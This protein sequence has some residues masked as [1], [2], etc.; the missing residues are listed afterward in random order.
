MRIILL[1]S[2]ACTALV[3]AG[4]TTAAMAND[5]Q[6]A[7]QG[8]HHE[9]RQ[10]ENVQVIVRTMGGEQQSI[11]IRDVELEFAQGEVIIN[12]DS[13]RTTS[14][15]RIII[16]GDNID[17]LNLQG[18][19]GAY[20]LRFNQHAD[21]ER[22]T[23]FEAGMARIEAMHP[24]VIH[25]EEMERAMAQVEREMTDLD[26]R[27]IVIVNGEERELTNE[28]RA[29][30]RREL[31][32]AREEIRTSIRDVETGMRA[33]EQE[34]R[35]ALREVRVELDRAER[36][37]ADADG[38][39]RRVRIIVRRDQERAEPLIRELRGLG[40]HRLRFVSE[41]GEERVWVDGEELEGEASVETLNRLET[42]RLAGGQAPEPQRITIEIDED[43]TD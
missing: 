24:D 39:M 4:C 10:D 23:R 9:Q 16:S 26:E 13:I 40:G 41:D 12:S 37:L 2:V 8:A 14:D 34:R 1:L 20:Q 33:A 19:N 30:I 18:S 43:E 15:G 3:A 28:A 31:A 36:E 6:S 35:Q 17:V 38:E 7:L 29:D 22:L 27:R 42:E 21:A 32:D 11:I 25:T 5:N